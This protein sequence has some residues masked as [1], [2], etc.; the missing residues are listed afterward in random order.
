MDFF[1][2]LNCAVSALFLRTDKCFA[3]YRTTFDFFGFF[4]FRRCFCL[5][6]LHKQGLIHFESPTTIFWYGT[7][8]AILFEKIYDSFQ[9]FS[10]RSV[11]DKERKSRSK[12][13]VICIMNT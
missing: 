8:V 7:L 9:L 10:S 2:F 1:P 11:C 3:T 12:P 5:S 4:V 6:V 13:F